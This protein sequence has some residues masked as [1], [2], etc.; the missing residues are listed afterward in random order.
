MRFHDER[1]TS[2]KDASRLYY[3]NRKEKTGGLKELQAC[4]L[5]VN[6]P[7]VGYYRPDASP[8]N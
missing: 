2:R 8:S 7:N 4:G 5:V 3:T 1:G 6:K